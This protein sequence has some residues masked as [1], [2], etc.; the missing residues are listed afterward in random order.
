MVKPKKLKISQ[1]QPTSFKKAHSPVLKEKIILTKHHFLSPTNPG[2]L[3][4]FGVHYS[5]KYSINTQP[6][7][8]FH[9]IGY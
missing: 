5:N 7:P 1:P 4:L 2:Q 3:V 8:P 6:N 9:N